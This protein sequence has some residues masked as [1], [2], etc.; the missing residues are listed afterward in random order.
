ML[1]SPTTAELYNPKV[2]AASKGSFLRVAVSYQPLD[3]FLA[4]LPSTTAVLGAYLDGESVHQLTPPPTGG[5][6]LLGS[7][8]QGISPP[9][10]KRVTRRITIPSFGAAESLN[11]GVAAAI[12]CDNLKRLNR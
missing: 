8:A 5:V 3:E 12:I 10:A 1:C 2:I 7:E 6:L 4:Q 11:V 9:L